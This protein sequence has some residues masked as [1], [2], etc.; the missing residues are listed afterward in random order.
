MYFCLAELTRARE[1]LH[2]A[3]ETSDLNTDREDMAK[4]KRRN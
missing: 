1:K 2:M 3:C 4:Q